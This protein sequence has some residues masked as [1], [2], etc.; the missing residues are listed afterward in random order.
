MLIDLIMPF[1]GSAMDVRPSESWFFNL[2][3][4]DCGLP[5]GSLGLASIKRTC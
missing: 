5:S 2:E 4:V 3:I 1:L